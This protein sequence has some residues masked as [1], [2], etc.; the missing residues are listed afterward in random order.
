MKKKSLRE[1]VRSCDGLFFI[2]VVSILSLLLPG[3][4]AEAQPRRFTPTITSLFGDVEI[5]G[6]YESVKNKYM[7]EGKDTTD[8]EFAEKFTLG[9]G[10]FVYHPNFTI[11]NF[12]VGAGVKEE[13]FKGI[14]TD[15]WHF[16]SV[17]EY[18]FKFLLLPKHK[19]SLEGYSRRRNPFV[20]GRISPGLNPVSYQHGINL[21]YKTRPLTLTLRSSLESLESGGDRTDTK[22]ISFNGTH[23]LGP[24]ATSLSLSHSNSESTTLANSKTN[25]Y[26]VNNNIVYKSVSFLSSLGVQEF[27]QDVSGEVFSD[28]TVDWEE[29]LHIRIFDSLSASANY[30]FKMIDRETEE[31]SSYSKA[32]TAGAGIMH[33]FYKSITTGYNIAYS[34]SESTSASSEVFSQSLRV[35]Y[36]KMIPRGVLYANYSGRWSETKRVGAQRI[37]DESHVASLIPPDDRFPLNETNADVNS[38]TVKVVEPDT[39]VRYDL[40]EEIHYDVEVIGA[41]VFITIISVEG[42]SSLITGSGPFTFLVDYTIPGEVEFKSTQD[43]YGIRLELFDRLISPYYQYAST[44]QDEIKGQIPGGPEKSESHTFGVTFH[45]KAVSL[46]V[47]Y[48]TVESRLNPLKRLMVTGDYREKVSS[49]VTL[50]VRS[51]YQKTTY[52]ETEMD[53][54]IREESKEDIFTL[55]SKANFVFSRYNLSMFVGGSFSYRK[56]HTEAYG[57]GLNSGVVWKVGLLYLNA[58]AAYTHYLNKLETGDA[59]REETF[60]YLRVKRELF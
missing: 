59:L 25:W 55:S 34:E 23:L 3:G 52:E 21:Y 42:I 38:I 8:I 56:R 13:Y 28:R 57:I 32:S 36:R 37:F 26:F 51:K 6:T 14:E 10:G 50:Q 29:R 7:G 49:K 39:D 33:R 48:Q 20:R 27:E 19:Y 31:G 54:E 4:K 43:T 17:T 40:A 47:E 45:R 41:D 16:G 30:G 9:V 24:S 60:V 22:S 12:S 11:F 15:D 46:G 44:K 35:N 58:G 2:V 1:R 53:G 18:E 5:S